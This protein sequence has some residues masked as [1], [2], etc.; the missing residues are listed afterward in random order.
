MERALEDVTVL[1][2]GQVIAMPYCTMLLA[3]LGARVIKSNRG[4]KG[5]SGC[6]WG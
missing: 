6:H 1:D 4:S 5:R 2:L 3:D